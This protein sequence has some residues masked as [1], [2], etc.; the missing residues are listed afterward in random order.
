MGHLLHAYGE[1]GRH[2]RG[3]RKFAGFFG[4]DPLDVAADARAMIEA[5]DLSSIGPIS[6]F[7][8]HEPVTGKERVIGSECAMQQYLDYVAVTALQQL[9]DAKIGYHQCASIRGKGQAHALKYLKRW[10]RS[11][12]SRYYVKLDVRKYYNNIDRD[13]LM[14]MLRRDVRNDDLLWLVEALIA[15][16]AKGLNIGSYLSQYLANYYLSGAYRYA[17]GLQKERKSRRTGE[18]TDVK[19]V[20]HV[21]TYM[22]DWVLIGWDKRD[23]KMAVRRLVRYMRDVLR[24]EVKPWKPC[25]IDC[26]P[27]D[28]I[29]YVFRRT[30][31]A[32]RAGIFLRARRAFRSADRALIL[33]PHL[34]ARCL[35]YWGYFKAACTRHYRKAHGIRKLVNDCKDVMSMAQVERNWYA[36]NL[37][38]GA[39]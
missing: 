29:G 26:E 8:R 10:V 27:I 32:V 30:W 17:E 20:G 35:A 36:N 24:L 16:H 9:F 39:A 38:L 34:A 22:D 2:R 33:T 12:S 3:K 23:L 11:S 21:L 13:V 14:G 19:L 25:A 37:Q 28:M 4:R 5:R 6:Y 18:V 31:T 7:N 15:T 1:F